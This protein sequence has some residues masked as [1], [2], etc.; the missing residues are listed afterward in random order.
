MVTEA[1]LQRARDLGA[2]RAV[3]AD[4]RQVEALL[5]DS[6]GGTADDTVA[7][8]AGSGAD[9]VINDNFA[10][11]AAKINFLLQDYHDR[12]HADAS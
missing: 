12:G 2:G 11:L 5:T 4:V 10:D 1:G 6:T 9:A 8:V 7:A 3:N